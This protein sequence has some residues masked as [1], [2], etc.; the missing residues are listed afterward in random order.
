MLNLWEVLALKIIFKYTKL[1]KLKYISH[2]DTLRL[3]QRALR[4]T[5][6]P[7]KYSE[8]FNPHPKLSIA[9]P[10]SL[11]IESIGEMAEV[12][13]AIRVER[14]VFV[15]KMNDSLPEG[16]QIISAS[17]FKG[18]KPLPAQI[19][20]QEYRLNVCFKS[21]QDLEQALKIADAILACDYNIIRVK[22]KKNKVTKK[23]INIV[24]YLTL[25]QIEAQ[26]DLTFSIDF[27]VA[28]TETG[29]LKIEEIRDFVSTYFQN[30][31]HLTAIR[32]N[33]NFVDKSV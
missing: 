29:S 16:L 31:D 22:E 23:E 27:K 32:T 30:I 6:L 17:E 13:L 26:S 28:I 20:S 2:L 25:M 4:R 11:G 33:L 9:F 5:G 19:V 8:G 14:D 1:G 15:N 21:N 7:A 10:L 3:L 18:N 12:E 24:E